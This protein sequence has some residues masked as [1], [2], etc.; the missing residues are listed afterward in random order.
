MERQDIWKK[1]IS[2]GAWGEF[3]RK[4]GSD[5]NQLFLL[6]YVTV[7]KTATPTQDR[8]PDTEA[9]L[10]YFYTAQK[11]PADNVIIEKE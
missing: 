4:E 8:I 7:V 1:M 9:F 3:I 2:S 11:V 6:H 10:P 5:S